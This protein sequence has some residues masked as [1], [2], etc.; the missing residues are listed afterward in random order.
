MH[1]QGDGPQACAQEPRPRGV[2]GP[3]AEANMLAPI[4]FR[5]VLES[6]GL[7]ICH[8]IYELAAVFAKLSV[9]RQLCL[10]ARQS[11]LMALKPG[12]DFHIGGRRAHVGT[13]RERALVGRQRA[14]DQ[15]SQQEAHNCGRALEIDLPGVEEGR[16]TLDPAIAAKNG[17][18]KHKG[19]G[20][21]EARVA[22]S[23]G[24]VIEVDSTVKKR[25][26]QTC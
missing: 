13:Q 22:Q 7:S 11:S 1:G 10:G 17:S 9:D 24:I 18:H 4:I 26:S 14:N 3:G 20:I 6:H 25:H 19:P 23:D 21:Q 2:A 12:H 5:D 8:G 15:A 16:F